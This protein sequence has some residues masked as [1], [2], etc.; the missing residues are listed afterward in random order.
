LAS[1]FSTCYILA[2]TVASIFTRASLND[3]SEGYLK[4]YC[5]FGRTARSMIVQDDSRQFHEQKF[6]QAKHLTDKKTSRKK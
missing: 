6:P 1:A 2:S 5:Y 3:F 4:S